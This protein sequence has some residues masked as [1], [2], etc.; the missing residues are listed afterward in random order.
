[1]PEKDV[2]R[3]EEQ[4]KTLFNNQDRLEKDREKDRLWFEGCVKELRDDVK[5]IKEQFAN[6]LPVW[7]TLLIALLTAVCGWLAAK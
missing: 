2:T 7:A 4:I 6:R 3:L 1:M 5:A